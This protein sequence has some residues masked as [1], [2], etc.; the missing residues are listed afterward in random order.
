MK[1]AVKGVLVALTYLTETRE[2]PT[3]LKWMLSFNFSSFINWGFK[4]TP[5]DMI[6]YRD[7]PSPGF[8]VTM[9]IEKKTTLGYIIG[10]WIF[11]S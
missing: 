2:D 10:V 11:I 7:A 1:I 5:E 4:F 8:M 6:T 3:T 9:L